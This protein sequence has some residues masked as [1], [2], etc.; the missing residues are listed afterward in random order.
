M[1]LYTYILMKKFRTYLYKIKY[2]MTLRKIRRFII[3][4]L[5]SG[6]KK[7]NRRKKYE[8]SPIALGS[9]WYGGM[10][11]CAGGG[12]VNGSPTPL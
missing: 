1:K 10:P 4:K 2:S 8:Y 7:M 12:V 6:K 3:S 5:L 9:S 11:Q